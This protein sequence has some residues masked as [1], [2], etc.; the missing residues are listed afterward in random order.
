[1]IITF[2]FL[3]RWVAKVYALKK[4]EK[5]ENEVYKFNS[6]GGNVIIVLGSRVTLI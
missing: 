1:M 2:Q 3:P 5:I 4:L 6:D